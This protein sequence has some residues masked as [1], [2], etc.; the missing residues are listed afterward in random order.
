[1]PPPAPGARLRLLAAAA[2][3]GL[4]VISRGLLS[5]SL[6]FSSPA[7]NYTV[8]EG[9][10]ATLSCFIDEHVTRV[11]WLNRSNILY[12]G[13]DR[14]T[15]DPRVRLL[16]NTQEEF[17]ILITQVG[18]GDEGLYTCSFQTRHQPYTTQVY[19]IVHDGFTSEG[20]ILEISDIQRG[21]AGEYEC[22]THNGVNSAPDSRRVLVT[23]NYPPTITDVTS[24]RTALGRAALLRCEAMAVPPAD[25]Q[26]YKDDRLLSS[27]SAE[28][29]KVQTERTRSMLLFANVSARHYGNYTCRAAN[30]LG[31][32]SASMRLL[33]ASSVAAVWRGGGGLGAVG[34]AWV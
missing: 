5:Q 25:F 18:L 23:V 4:A 9:D 12:A 13:N 30:R 24:A 7:D 17:S 22:V 21:Q 27:G 6:E 32:S 26:W 14:W 20:E 3:A 31:V 10:N 19:L 29:L 2:L 16:I 28:G 1:M 34:G 15:S 33:R 8:C 11:A